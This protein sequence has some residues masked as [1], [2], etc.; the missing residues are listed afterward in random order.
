MSPNTFSYTVS[1]ANAIT[2][3]F[4]CTDNKVQMHSGMRVNFRSAFPGDQ[5]LF[6]HYLCHLCEFSFTFPKNIFALLE[7]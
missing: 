5:C 4:Y 1:N 3:I 7:T 2:N 6:P